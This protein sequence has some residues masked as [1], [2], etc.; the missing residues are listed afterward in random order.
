[1]LCA[2]LVGVR[3]CRCR[4][5]MLKDRA[6][7]WFVSIFTR[8]GGYPPVWRPRERPD[9][10]IV[11]QSTGPVQTPEPDRYHF[12]RTNFTP[13]DHNKGVVMVRHPPVAGRRR[14]N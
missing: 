13:L 2:L 11:T 7:L 14:Q 9:P 8:G 12:V 10:P 5:P 4:S 3:K 1:M 6:A